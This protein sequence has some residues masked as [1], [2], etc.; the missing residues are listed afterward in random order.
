MVK[1]LIANMLNINPIISVD[2]SGKVSFFDKSFNQR[3]NMHK[4]MRYVK[5]TVKGK[6]VWNYIVLHANNPD[7]AYWF[8]NKMRILTSKEPVSVVN[9]SPVIGANTGTGTAAVTFIL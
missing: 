7:S 9:I 4:I 3:A 5:K 2:E 6:P 1:G 8:V